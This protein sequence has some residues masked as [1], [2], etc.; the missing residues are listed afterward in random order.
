[1]SQMSTE[2]V[3]LILSLF[4]TPGQAWQNKSESCSYCY[5]EEVF[6]RGSLSQKQYII[7]CLCQAI[8]VIEGTAR[9]GEPGNVGIAGH[10]DGFF[11]GLRL[12]ELGDG[13]RL[14]LAMDLVENARPLDL[15][16]GSLE[17]RC[18]KLVGDLFN[19]ADCDRFERGRG[20]IALGDQ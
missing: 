16:E 13:M 5:H 2:V 7:I 11:R 15:V 18:R 8:Q 4:L 9:L 20:T 10:R 6:P 19:A 12:L 17:D 1:M 14:Y 3:I